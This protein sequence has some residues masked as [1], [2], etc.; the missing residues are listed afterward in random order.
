[1]ERNFIPSGTIPTR[2]ACKVCHFFRSTNTF[3]KCVTVLTA[4]WIS[5]TRE[6]YP[7]KQKY[8]ILL[9]YTDTPCYY[10][11]NVQLI[12]TYCKR[13]QLP[14]GHNP[15]R[16]AQQTPS[17]YIWLGPIHCMDVILPHSKEHYCKRW[18][19]LASNEVITL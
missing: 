19:I 17:I 15:Y 3:P 5:V 4:R 8:F 10:A 6:N 11:W 1:M 9:H 14:Y 7:F 2:K 18:L 12:I 13:K 16:I